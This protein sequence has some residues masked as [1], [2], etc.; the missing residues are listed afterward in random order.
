[1]SRGKLAFPNWA[2]GQVL[3][4]EQFQAQ[5]E[6]VLAHIAVRA[7][8]SGLPDY[9]LARLA[10]DE[11]L[12]A[13]GSLS[14][15]RLTCLFASGLLIDVPGNAVLSN[16]NLDAVKLDRVSLYLHV[17]NEV[18]DATD[19]VRYEDDPRSVRRVIYRAELS[20]AARLDDARES[21]KLMELIRRDRQWRL[22]PYVPPLLRIGP[23]SSPFLRETLVGAQ[24]SIRSVEAQLARRIKDAF[25]GREQVAELRRVQAAAVRV[26]ALLADHG[27]GDEPQ[28]K[29]SLHPYLVFSALRDFYLEASLLPDHTHQNLGV[30]RYRHDDLGGCFTELCRG[31][32]G[33]LDGS[34]LS[35][36]RLEFERRASWWIAGPFPDGLAEASTVY[37][38]VKSRTGE[39]LSL[40]GVKL[41]SPRRIDEVYTRALS[42]VPLLP[43]NPTSS[44]AF[45]QIYGQDALIYEVGTRDPEWGLAARDSELCFPAWRDLETVSAA[46]VWGA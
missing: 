15:E 29:V 28:R 44:A 1:M 7:E 42:G 30:V 23:S 27:V 3:L 46:L 35:R 21:V 32:D 26:L 19:L 16:A 37:L 12:L 39:P 43:M 38:I 9:G 8:L 22:G 36:N 6:A 40:E 45:A 10:I 13:A 20:L 24:R 41:A 4:P 34:T 2:M 14:I 33:T 17:H 31:L 25:L 18:I 5:Q 11:T